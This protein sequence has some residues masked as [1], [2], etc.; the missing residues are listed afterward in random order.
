MKCVY[1]NET[2]YSTIFLTYW[3]FKNIVIIKFLNVSEFRVYCYSN[4]LEFQS[5]AIMIYEFEHTRISYVL[6]FQ[7]TEP[8]CMGITEF[9]HQNSD[10]IYSDILKYL[11]YQNFTCVGI[12]DILHFPIDHNYTSFIIPRHWH[13]NTSEFDTGFSEILELLEFLT[14]RIV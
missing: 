11:M 9:Q 1:L 2:F 7:C 14:S 10:V 8:S 5:I 12:S 3:N 6:K 13:Y 4:T